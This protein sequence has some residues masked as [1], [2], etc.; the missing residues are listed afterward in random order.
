[1]LRHNLA[2]MDQVP[3]W[4][5]IGFACQDEVSE[6]PELD[7]KVSAIRSEFGLLLN[8]QKLDKVPHFRPSSFSR[9]IASMSK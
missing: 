4:Q 1:M 7:D 5:R 6:I 8:E 9:L 2:V 3:P